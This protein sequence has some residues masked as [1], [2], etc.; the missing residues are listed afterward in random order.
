M[1]TEREQIAD[2]LR[3]VREGVRERA[4]HNVQ[5]PVHPPVETSNTSPKTSVE[6]ATILPNPLPTRT[7]RSFPLDPSPPVVPP[8]RPPDAGAVNA[9]WEVRPRQHPGGLRGFLARLAHRVLS[10]TLEAQV[11]FNS[12]QVQL[13][14]DILAYVDA[15]IEATHRHYDA[16]LG[17]HGRHMG[18]IDERHLI[19]QEELVAHVHDL[20]KRIDL[21]LSE[22]ER[23]RLSLEFAL[24]DLRA[25][26]VH[27]EERLARG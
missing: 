25:R 5:T 24:R 11:A 23:G 13:D 1:S 3:R 17:L 27:I 26:L 14:N 9:S 19:L 10:P 4:L 21:V 16:I 15:R 2:E 7:P 12:R 18:E 22:G 20:V 6:A 8:P